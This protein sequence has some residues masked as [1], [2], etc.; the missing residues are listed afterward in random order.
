MTISKRGKIINSDYYTA[1]LD[2][3]KAE[4]VRKRPHMAK[5]KF[6]LRQDNAPCHKSIKPMA[7]LHELRFEFLPHLPYNPNLASSDYWLFAGLKKM[8][9]GKKFISYEEAI[10][11][12]EAYFEVKTK[13]S[14]ITASRS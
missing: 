7:K 5:K 8:L 14:T 1:L 4:I 3:L 9:A 12:T 13:L 11:E 6:L 2:R 10:A